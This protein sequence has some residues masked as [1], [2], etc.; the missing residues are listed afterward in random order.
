[1]PNWQMSWEELETIISYM[2]QDEHVSLLG[3]EPSLHSEFDKIVKWIRGKGYQM[4][5]FS[6]GCTKKLRTI[7]KYCENDAI[8]IILNLN[9][10]DTYTAKEWEQ[11]EKNCIALGHYIS[12][13]YNIF[14]PEF[15]WEH[16]KKAIEDWG[17]FRHVRLGMTQPI[18]GMD[19]AFLQEKDFPRA[20]ERLVEMAVD[21]AES[22]ISLGFDCG[23]RSC[24][25]STE[26]LATLAECGVGLTFTCSPVLDI[27]PDLKVWRCFPFSVEEGEKLTDFDTM[28]DLEMHFIDKWKDEQAKGNTEDCQS[29]DNMEIT[30]CAGG[31]LS[32]TF[33]RHDKLK[34]LN[35]IHLK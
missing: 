15:T 16:T 18:K 24:D 33:R 21:F 29:C 6:N 28:Q 20:T 4:K 12:L 22:G 31:C 25:F 9:M 1:M 8:S 7:Q 19:N 13:S 27:G 14:E 23:F 17:L 26:Q 3:G 34:N 32:R 10:P 11:I 30:S 35:V 5:I 2:P